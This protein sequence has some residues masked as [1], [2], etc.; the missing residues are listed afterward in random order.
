MTQS[1]TTASGRMSRRDADRVVMS[2]LL[3]SVQHLIATSSAFQ[4][5]LAGQIINHVLDVFT[6]KFDATLFVRRDYHVGIGAVAV[7]NLSAANTLT[8][9][10]GGPGSGGVPDLGTGIYLIGPNTHRSIPCSQREFTIWGTSG[11]KLSVA[12]YTA[13]ITPSS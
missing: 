6:W 1:T 8:F 7:N 3:A 2:E 4:E 12:V 9:A 10:A 11:D 13:G 5:Q